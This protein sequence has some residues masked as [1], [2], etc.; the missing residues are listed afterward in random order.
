MTV[1][2]TKILLTSISLV[3][4][5]SLVCACASGPIAKWAS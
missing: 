3:G 4:V 1:A 2:S 5:R